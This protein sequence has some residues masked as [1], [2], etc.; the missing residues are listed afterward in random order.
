MRRQDKPLL[1]ARNGPAVV[2]VRTRVV[3]AGRTLYGPDTRGLVMS[4]QDSFD[5]D[6]EFDLAMAELLMA[7]RPA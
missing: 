1:F 2:A 5:N 7:S 3:T 4:R 6:D